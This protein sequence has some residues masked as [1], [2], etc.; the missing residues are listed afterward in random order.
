MFLQLGYEL[1]LGEGSYF[2]SGL[3]C[4][5]QALGNEDRPISLSVHPK[6]RM[7]VLEDVVMVFL[8]CFSNYWRF[9]CADAVSDINKNLVVSSIQTDMLGVDVFCL[10]K[11]ACSRGSSDWKRRSHPGTGVADGENGWSHPCCKQYSNEEPPVN[12]IDMVNP[13]VVLRRITC[14]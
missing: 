2:A 1:P 13:W 7:I 9:C 4:I 8:S 10:E 5:P 6:C 12:H 14:W 11:T 3:V